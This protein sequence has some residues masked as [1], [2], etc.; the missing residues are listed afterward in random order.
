M[1]LNIK[2]LNPQ[3][4]Q[5]CHTV[6]TIS[7]G[8]PF[9]LQNTTIE[10]NSKNA[11]KQIQLY[12]NFWS[13][14]IFD[15]MNG[16]RK[17]LTNIEQKL[18][19]SKQYGWLRSSMQIYCSLRFLQILCDQV[20][21]YCGHVPCWELLCEIVEVFA[22]CSIEVF[23]AG[24]MQCRNCVFCILLE[25]PV[26]TTSR[27]TIQV[28]MRKICINNLSFLPTLSIRLFLKIT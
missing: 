21:L 4:I 24:I 14:K 19:K 3:M 15:E 5:A 18:A 20:G 8:S 9:Q 22:F 26:F 6:K 11:I 16:L 28:S 12:Q 13:S 27:S 10:K 17:L 23:L 7:L 2:P 1:I 25:K